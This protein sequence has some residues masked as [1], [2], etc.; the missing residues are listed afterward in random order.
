[1]VGKEK[2]PSEMG[3]EGA[4]GELKLPLDEWGQGAGSIQPAGPPS[5]REDGP[6]ALS[7]PLSLHLY[8]A[9]PPPHKDPASSCPPVS[10]PGLSSSSQAHLGAWARAGDRRAE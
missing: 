7:R 2:E 9:Q 10:F 1:M 6:S 8:T 5:T 4:E 3:Q